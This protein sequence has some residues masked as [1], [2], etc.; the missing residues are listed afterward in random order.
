MKNIHMSSILY[1]FAIMQRVFS[2]SNRMNNGIFFAASKIHR[3]SHTIIDEISTYIHHKYY[4]N[5]YQ[6]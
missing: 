3:M 6:D 5:E 1:L 2:D 4:R